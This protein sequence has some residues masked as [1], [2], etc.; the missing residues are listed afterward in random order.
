MSAHIFKYAFVAVTREAPKEA[1]IS[2]IE[3][4][5]QNSKNSIISKE[6]DRLSS[7]YEEAWKFSRE[8]W[9][10]K[11]LKLDWMSLESG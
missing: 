11:A 1:R 9:Y 6:A 8:H 4:E 3:K 7:A 5:R 10:P 2:R